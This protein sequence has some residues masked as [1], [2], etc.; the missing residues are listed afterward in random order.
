LKKNGLI[1]LSGRCGKDAPFYRITDVK[2]DRYRVLIPKKRANGRDRHLWQDLPT[3]RVRMRTVCGHEYVLDP[4]KGEFLV[5]PTL[6]S[7]VQ[8]KE[9]ARHVNASASPSPK[10]KRRVADPVDIPAQ[11]VQEVAGSIESADFVVQLNSLVVEV[12]AQTPLKPRWEIIALCVSDLSRHCT[13][14]RERNTLKKA[15]NIVR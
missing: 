4:V 11:R 13:S 14:R 5:V 1:Q 6:P 3:T 9:K 15:A 2:G 10:K 7:R 8:Q 12:C